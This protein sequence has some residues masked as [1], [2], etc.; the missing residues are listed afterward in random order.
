MV[1]LRIEM[2][3]FSLGWMMKNIR[4]FNVFEGHL[5][6]IKKPMFFIIHYNTS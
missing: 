6:D 5:R 4:L 1:Q 2:Q 3:I